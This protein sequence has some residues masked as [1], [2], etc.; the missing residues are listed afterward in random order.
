MEGYQAYDAEIIVPGEEEVEEAPVLY[1]AGAGSHARWHSD[2]KG[3]WEKYVVGHAS[4]KLSGIPSVRRSPILNPRCCS[5]SGLYLRS[6]GI[7]TTIC[8][9]SV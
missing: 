9:A 7:S 5:L 6:A 2:S 1:R 4:A 8:G 3:G